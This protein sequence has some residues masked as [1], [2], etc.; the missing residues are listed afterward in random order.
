M[1]SISIMS[2]IVLLVVLLNIVSGAEDLS[3]LTELE[4]QLNER[5]GNQ[6]NKQSCIDMNYSVPCTDQDLRLLKAIEAQQTDEDR[7]NN[8]VNN[9]G[10][11]P[12]RPVRV[13]VYIDVV[14]P[15]SNG[16]AH[17]CIETKGGQYGDARECPPVGTGTGGNTT[18]YLPF[19]FGTKPTIEGVYLPEGREF[20]T[21]VQ[22]DTIDGEHKENCAQAKNTPGN[23]VIGVH[24]PF[25][26]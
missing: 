1:F 2:S 6:Q 17:V 16:T 21:C 18:T 24:I 3:N 8:F 10:A 5:W 14:A 11:T 25:L 7:W 19:A 22:I 26:H 20:F 23:D 12:D 4:K 13:L 9:G 15:L